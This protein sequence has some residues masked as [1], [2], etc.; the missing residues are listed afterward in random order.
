MYTHMGSPLCPWHIS[1]TYSTNAS[2]YCTATTLGKYYYSRVYL[3]IAPWGRSPAK[4]PQPPRC[5]LRTSHNNRKQK[6]CLGTTS[7]PSPRAET[8]QKTNEYIATFHN[9]Y[10]HL[11]ELIR[12]ASY[13]TNNITKAYGSS[14]Q[15]YCTP[16]CIASS[17][18]RNQEGKTANCSYAVG[19]C[20]GKNETKQ[21]LTLRS[22]KRQIINNT[23]GKNKRLQCGQQ[24]ATIATKLT[25]C[26]PYTHVRVP[27]MS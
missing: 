13:R 19:M 10:V 15:S 5:V 2:V 25:K 17:H 1:R 8:K 18:P 26:L 4:P 24:T 21:K 23:N 16:T 3:S 7:P 27:G 6:K 22:T 9:I 12:N 14:Y 20:A 11:V